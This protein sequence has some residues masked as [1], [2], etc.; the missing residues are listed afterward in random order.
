MHRDSQAPTASHD[1]KHL[2]TFVLGSCESEK[3]SMLG[4]LLMLA[5]PSVLSE[6]KLEEKPEPNLDGRSTRDE[7]QFASA[8]GKHG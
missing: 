6:T 3:R 7:H 2:R 8:L 5:F 4:Q 1:H